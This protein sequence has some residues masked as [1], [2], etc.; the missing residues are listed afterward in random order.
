MAAFDQKTDDMIFFGFRYCLGRM[1]CAVT[2]C[3]DYLIA[4]WQ[5]LSPD[6]QARIHTEIR[7]AFRRGHY[8]MDMDKRQWERV[9]EMPLPKVQ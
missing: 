8:G 7:E 2:I 1:S 6:T 3:V 9:L 4:H 5:H